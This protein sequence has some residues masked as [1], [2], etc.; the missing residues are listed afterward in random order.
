MKKLLLIIAALMLSSS[1][2]SVAT[3]TAAFIVAKHSETI[4][5]NSRRYAGINPCFLKERPDAYKIAEL[6]ANGEPISREY[7][8][9]LNPEKEDIDPP[10]PSHLA[11]AFYIIADRAGDVR[12]PDRKKWLA[13]YLEENEP[14]KIEE[15]IDMKYLDSFVMKCFSVPGYYKRYVSPRDMV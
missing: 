1:C 14:R 7:D 11:Y 3:S 9:I 4:E 2:S 5:R 8:I 13:K 12:A 15:Y 10:L 6:I